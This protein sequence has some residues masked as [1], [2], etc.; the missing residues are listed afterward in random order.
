MLAN[1]AGM[2]IT[3]VVTTELLRLIRATECSSDPDEY[4]LRVLRAELSRRLDAAAVNG[5]NCPPQRGEA[6]A[7]RAAQSGQEVPRAD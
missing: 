6:L 7:E 3:D 2:K 5:D 1:N 4:A